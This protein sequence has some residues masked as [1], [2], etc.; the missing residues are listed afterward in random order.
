MD[1]MH[2]HKDGIRSSLKEA[3]VCS[4]TCCSNSD[5]GCF[6]GCVCVCVCAFTVCGWRWRPSLFVCDADGV[7]LN[8]LLPLQSYL[9]KLQ[10]DIGKT[11]EKVSS[12]EKYINNQLEHLVQEYRSAQAQL[13]EV[14][15][16]SADW[17]CGRMFCPDVCPQTGAGPLSHVVNRK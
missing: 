14:N 12:R 5:D 16:G 9:D 1:Q 2:Q 3:K 6:A 4:L 10:E 13:S 15:A 8:P 7:L 17:R 11:L